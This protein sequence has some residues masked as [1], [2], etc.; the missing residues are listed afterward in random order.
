MLASEFQHVSAPSPSFAHALRPRAPCWSQ[1]EC[2]E[3]A[4]SLRF[5]ASR[6]LVLLAACS[7]EWEHVWDPI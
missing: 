4:T 1:D 7:Y 6:A 2:L 5:V 3:P